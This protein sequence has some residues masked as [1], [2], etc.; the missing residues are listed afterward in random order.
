[1]PP[2][3]RYSVNAGGPDL[4]DPSEMQDPDNFIRYAAG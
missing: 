3:I 4:T 1:M 2:Q